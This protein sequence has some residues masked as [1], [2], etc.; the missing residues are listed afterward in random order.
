[1]KIGVFNN[2]DFSN[3]IIRRIK[4]KEAGEKEGGK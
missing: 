3:R 1:M 4:A 2:S